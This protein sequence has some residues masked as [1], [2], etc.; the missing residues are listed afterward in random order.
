MGT[1]LLL[2]LLFLNYTSYTSQDCETIFFL[3]FLVTAEYSSRDFFSVKSTLADKTKLTEFFEEKKLILFS[4]IVICRQN[5][6]SDSLGSNST[7]FSIEF[8][9]PSLL[10]PAFHIQKQNFL[11]Y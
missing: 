9:F 4:C 10:L 1:C 5:W 6:N 8:S 2:L 3:H 11:K 7:K